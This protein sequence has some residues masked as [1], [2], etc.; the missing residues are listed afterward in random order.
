MGFV[1]ETGF[2]ELPVTLDV[3]DRTSIRLLLLWLTLISTCFLC[4]LVIIRYKL[5]IR[6]LQSKRLISRKDTI[7][8]TGD[9][10]CLM[11]ELLI[12]NLIPTP[13]YSGFAFVTYNETARVE[14]TYS[15]NEFFSLLILLRVLMVFRILLANSR[16]YT[17]SA[18]RICQLTGCR[19][20]YLFVIKSLMKS[21]PLE[22][23]SIALF[24]SIVTFAY[25]IKV[26]ERPLI[27]ALAEKAKLLN[28]KEQSFLPIAN[29]VSNYY[30]SLWLMIVT[31]TTVGYGDF[32]P[33]TIPGKA[34]TFFAC[35]FGVIVVSLSTIILFNFIEMNYSETRSY[36][37]IEK[38]GVEKEKRK[39]AAFVI[40]NLTKLGFWK[41]ILKKIRNEDIQYHV[42]N[43]KDHLKIFRRLNNDRVNLFTSRN[44]EEE[45]SRHFTFLRDDHK[46]LEE[47]V[48]ELCGANLDLL[49]KIGIV[50]E[51]LEIIGSD[52]SVE[53]S[54]KYL[55]TPWLKR[56]K[57]KRKNAGE[58]KRESDCLN[59]E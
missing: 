1:Q 15:Y 56:R 51:E 3:N 6:W 29:D 4:P 31:M 59:T 14:T 22:M 40:T 10:Y 44:I 26:C 13:F 47:R 24:I 25:A 32:A 52:K 45:I 12:Y 19:N 34:I 55:Y 46:H 8:T 50:Q 49:D 35:I 7:F 41:G 33:R 48:D 54:E 23:L 57:Y 9:I 42:K 53:C 39:H 2:T 43:I 20:G 30:N 38:I 18:H 16:Y 5:K 21:N 17:N 36:S 58:A 27:Y 28:P 37:I 11:L